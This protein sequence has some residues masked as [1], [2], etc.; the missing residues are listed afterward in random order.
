[1]PF[2]NWWQYKNL[3]IF[4]VSILMFGLFSLFFGIKFFSS[5]WLQIYYR[6]AQILILISGAVF[7]LSCI[8][9]FKWK[10]LARKLTLIY[11]ITLILYFIPLSIY[12]FSDPS[13][14]GGFMVISFFPY[15][16]FP[17]FLIILLTRP[18]IKER[19]NQKK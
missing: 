13:G 6:I 11:S 17:L 12:L 18:Q 19:F 1:M 9:L 8:I 2:V 15:I 3:V 4:G 7:V 5:S 16:L 10:E 14:W